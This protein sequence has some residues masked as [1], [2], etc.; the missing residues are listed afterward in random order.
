MHDG[1]YMAA[2]GSNPC[3]H[4]CLLHPEHVCAP[5]VDIQ[6]MVLSLEDHGRGHEVHVVPPTA[7]D[8]G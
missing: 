1:R 8:R 7:R 6:G 5:H 4:P 2:D 3:P